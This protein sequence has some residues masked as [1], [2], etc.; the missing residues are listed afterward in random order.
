MSSASTPKRSDAFGD[1]SNVLGGAFAGFVMALP[2]SFLAVLIY[3][4]RPATAAHVNLTLFQA[5]V[6]YFGAGLTGGA[7]VGWFLPLGRSRWG[8]GVLGFGA[9]YPLCLGFAL[10]LVW[11]TRGIGFGLGL[12]AIVALILGPGIAIVVRDEMRGKAK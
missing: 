10:P 6:V 2:L 7:I 11:H 4:V 8:A 12:A 9:V 5:L 3:T 1:R